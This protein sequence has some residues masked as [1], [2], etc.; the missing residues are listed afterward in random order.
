MQGQKA[1]CCS[2]CAVGDVDRKTAF[3]KG[4]QIIRR[5]AVSEGSSNAAR[6]ALGAS[7]GLGG[8]QLLALVLPSDESPAPLIETVLAST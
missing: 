6:A 2:L 4:K 5:R 3:K 7:M 1:C 8:K